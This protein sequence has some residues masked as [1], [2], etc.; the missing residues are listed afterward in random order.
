MKKFLAGFIAFVLMLTSPAYANLGYADGETGKSDASTML[1]GEK[2]TVKGTNSF[3][4]MLADPLAAKMDEQ[5][6]NAGYNVFSIEVRGKEASVSFETLQDAAL[7]VGIYDEDG[8]AMLGSGKSEVSAGETEVVVPIE[9]DTMP[10]YFYL[11]GFL[12]DEDT[13]RPLCTVYESPNYTREM[14]EFFEKTTDNFDADR[15]LNLDNDKTNNFAVYSKNVTVISGAGITV[16]S[17]DEESNTYVFKNAESIAELKQGD[18]FSYKCDDGNVLIVKVKNTQKEGDTITVTGM[19]TSMEDVFEYVKIDTTS[20]ISSM[21]VDDST[22][23]EGVVCNGIVQGHS[24][25]MHMDAIIDDGGKFGD[26]LSYTFLESETQGLSGSVTFKVVYSFKVYISLSYQYVESKMDYSVSFGIKISAKDGIDKSLSLGTIEASPVVGVFVRFTPSF[27]VKVSASLEISGDLSGTIGCAA[28]SDYGIQ[29]LTTTPKI[30][31]KLEGALTIFV[32]LSLEPEVKIISKRIAKTSMDAMVG[33]EIKGTLTYAK[34]SPSKI[35]DCISCVDG[36]ISWSAKVSF[37]V[38]FLNKWDKKFDASV[39]KKLC[40][41]YYSFDYKEF[42]F[43]SCP[44]YLY[45]ITVEVVDTEGHPVADAVVNA[46]FIILGENENGEVERQEVTSVTTDE[47]GIAE[48]YF[49]SGQYDF[50]VCASDYIEKSKKVEVIDTSKKVKVKLETK[51]IV[52]PPSGDGSGEQGG[53]IQPEIKAQILSLGDY[54]SAVITEDGSLHMWGDSSSGKFGDW[55]V[56][57]QFEPL[58][59]LENVKTV[60]LGWLHSGAVTEDGKLHMWGNNYYGQLGKQEGEELEHVASVSLGSTHT[61]AIL[62]DGSLYM[63]GSNSCGELGY[64]TGNDRYSSIPRKV[65]ENVVSVSL[66]GDHTGAVTKDGNLYMWGSNAYG[67]LGNG[68]TQDSNEP[69]KILENVASVSLGSVHSGAITKNGDLYMWGSNEYG[70]LG[71]GTTDNSS[72]PIKVMENVKAVSLGKQFSGAIKEDGNLYMWGCNAGGNLGNGSTEERHEPVKVAENVAAVSL[73]AFHSGMIKEDGSLYMWGTNSSGQLGDGSGETQLR[74]VWIMGNAKLKGFQTDA[75]QTQTILQMIEMTMQIKKMGSLTPSGSTNNGLNRTASFSS[76]IPNVIYNFY[77]LKDKSVGDLLHASNLLYLTQA[78][79]QADGSLQVT[80]QSDE[81]DAQAA[82]FL[83]SAEQE[84]IASAD[85]YMPDLEYNQKQQY[86]RPAVTHQGKN[87]TEGEDYELRGD[88]SATDIGNYT[89]TIHGIGDYKGL[90]N[91]SYKITEAKSRKVEKITLSVADVSLNAG[92]T[93][94]LIAEIFPES[95]E[96]KTLR[97]S[98]SDEQVATVDGNGLVTAVGAGKATITVESQDGSGIS[99]SCVITVTRVSDDLS[100]SGSTGDS[101]GG[102]TGGSPWDGN[103]SGSS[104]GATIGG[105]PSSNPAE[106]DPNNG[107]N[108][109]L[110]VELMYYIVHFNANGGNSLSRKTMTL[111]LDDTL[112]ILPKIQRKQYDFKGWY[113]QKSGGEKVTQ[114]TV[115][116]ASTTLYAR[117][118][119]VAKAAKLAKVSLIAKKGR[120][121]KVRYKKISGISGYQIAYSTSEKFAASATKKVTTDSTNII[122]K[123]L[124]KGKTY[125]VKV[126]AYKIDSAGNKVYGAYSGKKSVKIKA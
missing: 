26:S 97:W 3:G 62:E 91:A 42:A 83:V 51:E 9:I 56:K 57:N 55:T 109:D 107:N 102:T 118:S 73:G 101:S 8:I 15:V 40:D 17:I 76:L 89:V 105:N 35:H 114:A 22:C 86:V 59:V 47:N 7:V 71:D 5:G 16:E 23:G 64:D 11:R 52:T 121:M 18:T 120:Q 10:R 21:T 14:Q 126:R 123:N 103:S 99:A 119:K 20:D 113:T 117:W 43:T 80:Y 41:W 122:L 6:S 1:D 34:P 69:V 44:H 61:G 29:N 79:A 100:G 67:K 124:K 39:F 111:L 82:V 108:E 48:G 115:L 33:A 53:S 96:N 116:N 88:Y 27:V 78:A 93:L 45:K 112:G 13:L 19:D 30:N 94:Q 24:E 63:W 74:P 85:V 92:N 77:V 81:N 66:G 12:V 4:A 32:G 31:T 46:P 36:E 58:K 95:A 68:T 2:M 60:S 25:E 38:E 49:A 110:Q 104:S 50:Y 106:N 28:S 54:H 75:G 98:S 87:L 84:D 72:K 125:Y 70:E 37:K 65:L 90:V